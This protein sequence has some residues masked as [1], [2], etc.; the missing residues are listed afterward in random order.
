[1]FHPTQDA[2][3][4]IVGQCVLSVEVGSAVVECHS[5]SPL[6]IDERREL[7]IRRNLSR[8]AELGLLAVPTKNAEKSSVRQSLKRCRSL[9]NNDKTPSLRKSPRLNNTQ[10][11]NVSNEKPVMVSPQTVLSDNDSDS[12]SDYRR[13]R[14]ARRISSAVSPISD[15]Y[16]EPQWVSDMEEWLSAL[17]SEKNC[18]SVMKQVRR[19][20]AGAGV[21]YGRWP[22]GVAFYK[23]KAVDLTMDL[24]L[25][26][27]EA[28][29][30]ENKHGKDLGNGWLLL[31]PIQKMILYKEHVDSK[32]SRKKL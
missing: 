20:A 29:A 11:T 9:F 21:E 27:N 16:E 17:V 31:H 30:F 8:L 26:W 2:S 4:Q 23:N 5:S 6:T 18:D 1:M 25:L 32:K 13:R 12:V 22:Q 14:R 10:G 19:L 24:T 7:N 3:H 28:A 15:D